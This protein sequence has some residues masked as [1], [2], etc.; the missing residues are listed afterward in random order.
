MSEVDLNAL[1]EQ[2]QQSSQQQAGT[3]VS[4][5]ALV[6]QL[7]KGYT[8]PAAAAPEANSYF[9]DPADDTRGI[10]EKTTDYMTGGRREFEDLSLMPRLNLPPE[11]AAKL[12]GLLATTSSDD[13]LMS[14]VSDIIPGAQFDKDKYNN[15]IV[16]AP[17]YDDAGNPTERRTK[18]YPNP[19]G[20]QLVNAMQVAGVASL[21]NPIVGTLKRLGMGANSMLTAAT[22]GG[23]EAGL[24]EG[25]SSELSNDNYQTLDPVLGA[26]G[27]ALGQKAFQFLSFL[28]RAYLT[29]PPAVM[30]QYGNFTPSILKM[31]N[32]LG[33][34]PSEVSQTLARNIAK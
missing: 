4:I 7:E 14:G 10:V 33:L 11:K 28:K 25:A 32:D 30:D 34:D 2:L 9:V 26:G 6:E 19:E 13:R 20:F 3:Q 17:I 16:V 22:A 15:L 27:G 31:I 24:I 18:F 21:A 5:E 29:R 8:P 23:I 1:I 12:T